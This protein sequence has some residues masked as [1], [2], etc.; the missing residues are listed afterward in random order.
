MQSSLRIMVEDTFWIPLGG[1]LGLCSILD[2]KGMEK[3]SYS[4]HTCHLCTLRKLIEF[5]EPL[6]GAPRR[7]VICV[8]FLTW[9]LA[10]SSL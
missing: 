3:R 7:S 2:L 1:P 4:P 9:F 8:T 6:F 5:P 10:R